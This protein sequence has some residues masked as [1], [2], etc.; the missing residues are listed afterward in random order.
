M[1]PNN[2]NNEMNISI[3]TPFMVIHFEIDNITKCLYIDS[4]LSRTIYRKLPV[5]H[6]KII[7]K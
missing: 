5:I 6:Q 7:F 1:K 2:E 4:K 3:T